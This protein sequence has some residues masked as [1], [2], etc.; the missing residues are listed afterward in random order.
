MLYINES[1]RENAIHPAYEMPVA[2]FHSHQ[3]GL[4][5]P[6]RLVCNEQ[7]DQNVSDGSDDI[8]P[9]G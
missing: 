8:Q 6:D 4:H 3:L 7:F 5:G 9:D 1:C 2:L